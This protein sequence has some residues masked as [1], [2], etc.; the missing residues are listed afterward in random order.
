VR[1]DAQL[2]E[3]DMWL[4]EAIITFEQSLE[5][6]SENSTAHYNLELCCRQLGEG[7]KADHHGLMHMKYKRDDSIA[8]EIMGTA[9]QRCP[10]A[11]QAAEA[12][13]I[14]SLNGRPQ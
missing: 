1:T 14:Y 7:S 12:V 2:A 5:L 10:A 11:D 4:R 8:G 6:D 13:V 3:R 9:R